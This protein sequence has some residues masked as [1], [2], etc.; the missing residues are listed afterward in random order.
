MQAAENGQ[1]KE[2]LAWTLH[3]QPSE[4][5]V[6]NLLLSAL[7]ACPFGAR[8][9]RLPTRAIAMKAIGISIVVV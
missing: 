6:T 4:G 3:S 1:L 7:V 2:L 8:L 9:A 5:W